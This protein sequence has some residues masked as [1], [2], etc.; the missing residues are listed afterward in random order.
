MLE[1]RAVEHL[2]IALEDI[3]SSVAMVHVKVDDSHLF[4]SS[5]IRSLPCSFI[6]Q[7]QKKGV[8]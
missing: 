3:F 4:W 5:G 6:E 8:Q 1:A 7:T 2:L